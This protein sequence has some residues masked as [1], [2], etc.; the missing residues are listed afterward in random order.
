MRKRCIP[1]VLKC[2]DQVRRSLQDFNNP[3]GFTQF[4]ALLAFVHIIAGKL[5]WLKVIRVDEILHFY[6]V[7]R[8]ESLEEAQLQVPEL[9]R[10]V[11]LGAT[12]HALIDDLEFAA[13]DPVHEVRTGIGGGGSA[14]GRG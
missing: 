6:R 13:E 12:L 8:L 9:V 7:R 2:Q 5:L 1:K 11:A 14:T 4:S 3:L 10:V